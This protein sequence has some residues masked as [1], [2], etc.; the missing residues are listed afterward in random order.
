[1]KTAFL[2]PG[3]G[4][5]APGMG[6]D[7]RAAF[8]SVRQRLEQA[9]SKLGIDLGS[10][11]RKGPPRLLAETRYAQPAIFALSV[12]IAELLAAR[13]LSPDSVAGHSLGEFS[14]ACF[15]KVLTFDDALDLVIERGR[16]MHEVNVTLNGGMMAVSGVSTAALAPLLDALQNQIWIANHNAPS[17]LILSGLRRALQAA[18]PRI[19]ESGGRCTVLDVAGPYHTPLLDKAA[20]SFALHVQSVVLSEPAWPLIANASAEALVSAAQIRPELSAHMVSA[21]NWTGTMQ[22]MHALGSSM[23]LEVGPGRIL[24]GLALRNLPAVPSLCTATVR[25]F[26]A[27]C[28]SLEQSLCASS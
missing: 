6:E 25:E 21:V 26:D 27:S 11:M 7:F 5:Q 13:G 8:P 3:Q 15:A 2:F 20:Q 17:Q 24:K 4:A 14:A 18:E 12:A 19:L 22:T 28:R 9:G 1:M 10:L 23:L 16:L